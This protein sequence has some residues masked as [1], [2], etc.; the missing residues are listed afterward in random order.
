MKP[1]LQLVETARTA[2]EHLPCG[3]ESLELEK[4]H[5]RSLAIAAAG[6]EIDHLGDRDENI[7][8]ADARRDRVGAAP[9]NRHQPGVVD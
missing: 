6:P 1:Q 9:P 3:C 4:R 5:D 8:G 2:L 7:T